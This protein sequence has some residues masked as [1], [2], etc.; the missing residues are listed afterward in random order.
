[1]RLNQNGKRTQMNVWFRH[2]G[3]DRKTHWLGKPS[4]DCRKSKWKV[5]NL[6]RSSIL[7]QRYTKLTPS[8]QQENIFTKLDA[9]SGYW[10]I[11]VDEENS[12]LIVFCSP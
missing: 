6:L 3:I 10:Q 2:Y 7:G 9:F 5:T 11:E 8:H 12:N 4:C 1:M